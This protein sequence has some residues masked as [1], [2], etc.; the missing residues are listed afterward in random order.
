MDWPLVRDICPTQGRLYHHFGFTE[1]LVSPMR[2]LRTHV[3][4]HPPLGPLRSAGFPQRVN[5][6]CLVTNGRAADGGLTGDVYRRFY[7]LDR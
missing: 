2:K 4:L 6:Q 5:I 3:V 7:G 1:E